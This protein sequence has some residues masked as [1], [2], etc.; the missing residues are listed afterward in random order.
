MDNFCDSLSG[1]I[2]YSFFFTPTAAGCRRGTDLKRYLKTRIPAQFDRFLF[3]DDPQA[4][5]DPVFRDLSTSEHFLHANGLPFSCVRVLLKDETLSCEGITI[6]ASS[7]LLTYYQGADIMQLAFNFSFRDADTNTLIYMHHMSG[8]GVPFHDG[9]GGDISIKDLFASLLDRLG[10]TYDREELTNTYQIELNEAYGYDDL[11]ALTR[12]QPQRLY[13]ILSGDE[14]WRHVP[15]E[16]ASS[17]VKNMWSSRDFVRLIIFGPNFIILNLNRGKRFQDYLTDQTAFGTKFYGGLNPYFA[18]R[19]TVAGVNHGIF[20]ALE[21]G[22]VV[23]AIAD[24]TM[25]HHEAYQRKY[26]AGG[27]SHSIHMTKE[28]R[29]ELIS[30]LNRVESIEMTELGEL[31]MI[32]L[33][34]QRITPIIDKVKYLLELLESELDLLYQNR[35]NTMVTI[36]TVAG[37]LISVVGVVYAHLQTFGF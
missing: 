33:E 18:M 2:T 31:E 28:Y 7:I 27:F 3:Y 36:L 6:T 29:R 32:V 30:T 5:A 25:S 35:T 34:S 12:E 17:R 26:G 10:I 14:G 1:N 21:T 20:F 37:L 9:R 4:E 15:M 24:R 8:N 19:A 13:G 22:M 11:D 23:K 16:L